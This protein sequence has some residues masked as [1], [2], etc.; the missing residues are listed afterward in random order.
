MKLVL[1]RGAFDLFHVGHLRHLKEARSL[2]DRLAVSVNID[3]TI[4]KGEGRPVFT[5]GERAEMLIAQRTVDWVII[6]K[7]ED[8]AQEILLLKPAFYV[9]GVDYE[10]TGMTE[11]ER[12][13][14]TAVGAQFVITKAKKYSSTS[15]LGRVFD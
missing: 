5:E 6:G 15:A 7:N 14:C 8:G 4:H 3:E 13:A 2:G 10:G 1:C 12:D 11:A 9:K